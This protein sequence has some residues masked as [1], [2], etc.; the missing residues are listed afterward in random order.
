MNYS[1]RIKCFIFCSEGNEG[2]K[3]DNIE[4]SNMASHV[5]TGSSIRSSPLSQYPPGMMLIFS[6]TYL[7]IHNSSKILFYARCVL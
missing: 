4:P 6:A 2:S 1:M 5:R 7:S 3:L